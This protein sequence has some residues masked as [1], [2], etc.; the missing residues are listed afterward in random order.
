[1]L[2]QRKEYPRPQFA[3][4]DWMSLNGTWEFCFDDEDD[5]QRRGLASGKKALS[6]SI[7]VPFTYEYPASGIGDRTPHGVVWYRRDQ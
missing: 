5:G 6:M 7:N 3:R 2:P 1:M 4:D